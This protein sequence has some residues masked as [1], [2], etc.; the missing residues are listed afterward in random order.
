M[1]PEP[2]NVWLFIVFMLVPLTNVFCFV[3]SWY[4]LSI[5]P[6]SFVKSDTFVGRSLIVA[7]LFEVALYVPFVLISAISFEVID[8]PLILTSV[9]NEPPP[10][11]F[12]FPLP[13]KDSLLIVLILVPDTNVS[14]LVAKAASVIKPLSF[15]NSLV[16]VGMKKSVSTGPEVGSTA[17]TPAL[18]STYSF[19]TAS[20]S[21]LITDNTFI[22]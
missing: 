11:T 4:V 6:L 15:V 9:G 18:L 8:V 7:I 19:V 3:L 20:L 5:N 10:D 12:I 1:F 17:V 22:Y 16:F 21:L 13:N 14:C 2:N